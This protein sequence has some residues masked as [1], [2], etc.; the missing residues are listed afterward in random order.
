M[1]DGTKSITMSSSI[2]PLAAEGFDLGLMVLGAV[3]ALGVSVLVWRRQCALAGRGAAFLGMLCAVTMQAQEDGRQDSNRVRL[4][5]IP[6]AGKDADLA[7][8]KPRTRYYRQVVAQVE[9]KWQEYLKQMDVPPGLVEIGFYVNAKGGV[10]NVRVVNEVPAPPVLTDLTLR[11][12]HDADIPAIPAEVIPTLPAEE[13]GRMKIVFG[14]RIKPDTSPLIEMMEEADKELAKVDKNQHTPAVTT[15]APPAKPVPKALWVP[16]DEPATRNQD[17]NAYTPFTR[18]PQTKGTP[19]KRGEASVD[20]ADTPLGRYEREVRGEVERKWHIYLHL[21]RDGLN[22]GYLQLVFYVNKKG[23]VERLKV[24]ND[25]ESTPFLT[26]IT[27]RAIKDAKIPPMPADVIP[28]LPK[29]DPECL[30]IQYDV[31]IY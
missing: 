6:E 12:V 29:T 30:K 9:R 26:E 20:A 10:E 16:D 3:C 22:K 14:A 19:L 24:I 23:K 15:E 8:E 1:A 25:K 18:T 7:K 11:A 27:L 28:L 2:E 21:R 13:G 4:I 31:L 17:P 5:P